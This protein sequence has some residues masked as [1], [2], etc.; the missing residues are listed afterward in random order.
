MEIFI[1]FA[2]IVIAVILIITILLQ[3]K[4]SGLGGMMGGSG[5]GASFRT[6]RGLERRLFQATIALGII[7]ILL[8]MVS[9][10]LTA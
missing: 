10:R 2:Q 6:R 4:G 5:G 9:V 7:F 8:S 3:A 1:Y